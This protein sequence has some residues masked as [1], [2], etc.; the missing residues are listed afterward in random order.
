M[1]EAAIFAAVTGSFIA[2]IILFILYKKRKRSFK[3]APP[4]LSEWDIRC[5]A[6]HEAGHAVCSNFLPEREKMIR[7]TI[8]PSDAAFGMIKTAHRPY[9]NE[10]EVSLMSIVATFLA[11][12]ISEEKFLNIKTTSC[13]YDLAE[14]RSVAV[15]MVSKFGMGKRMKKLTCISV[16]DNSYCLYSEHLKQMIDEDVIDILERANSMAEEII[17]KHSEDVVR[18]AETLFKEK[19]LCSENIDLF[20]K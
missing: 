15:N 20:F 12:R 3:L 4:L 9:Y 14:A 16:Y 1:F 11:G 8:D 19:T 5:M 2:C 7:I 10:T 6:Y 13:I 17:D 18:L